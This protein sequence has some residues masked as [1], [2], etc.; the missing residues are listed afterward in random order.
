MIYEAAFIIIGYLSGSIPFGLIFSQLFGLGDIRKIGSG[1]IGATNVL[2]SGNKTATVLTLVFDFLKGFIPVAMYVTGNNIMKYSL[3]RQ[4]IDN[5]SIFIALVCILGHIFPVWLK[6][7]GGKGIA[8]TA[9]VY[10]AL[11]P[12]IGWA[13]VGVWLVVLFVTRVS[14]VAA[15]ASFC[16]VNPLIIAWSA[17]KDPLLFRQFVFACVVTFIIVITHSKNIGRLLKGEEAKID[18]KK[19]KK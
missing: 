3:Q 14:S 17:V 10:C 12:I 5:V 4:M 19:K 1:N 16:I 15:I 9:G 6:F 7:K 18:L 2:R 13:S 8:T 11:M